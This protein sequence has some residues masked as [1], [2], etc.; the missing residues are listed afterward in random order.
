M[1]FHESIGR[2]DLPGGNYDVLIQSIQ[3]RLFVLDDN[4][5]VFSGHGPKTTIG[6]EKKHNPFLQI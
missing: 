5:T 1:L 4:Y 2:T 6:H 3:T